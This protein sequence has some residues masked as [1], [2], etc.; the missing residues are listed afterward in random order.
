MIQSKNHES[1]I[2]ITNNEGLVYQLYARK[3]D[4]YYVN[5]ITR[6]FP[7]LISATT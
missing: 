2:D 5:K 1:D 6:Y 7:C 3:Q 4:I